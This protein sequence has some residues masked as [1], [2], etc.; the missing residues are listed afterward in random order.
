MNQRVW[1]EPLACESLPFLAV[2]W[3]LGPYRLCSS[4]PIWDQRDGQSPEA[5]IPTLSS[6]PFYPL[7]YPLSPS[8]IHVQLAFKYALDLQ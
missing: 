6:V 2:S 7:K 1:P 3:L 8:G 5:T 4:S